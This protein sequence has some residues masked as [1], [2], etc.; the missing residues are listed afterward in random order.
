MDQERVSG[1]QTTHAENTSIE[2]PENRGVAIPM[3]SHN[4]PTCKLISTGE[5]LELVRR[6]PSV[7]LLDVRTP[8]EYRGESGH[9][10]NSVLV[11]LQELEQRI[12]ELVP[13]KAR[14][15]IAYCRS[16]NRSG[17]A[18]ATLTRKGFSA[19]NMEGG[20]VKWNAENL[21]VIHEPNP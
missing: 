21:P 10:E 14:T 2:R 8:D 11:P 17:T 1:R 12:D 15:I 9:L 5:T 4:A 16:G 19:M 7:L 3:P 20:M 13:Y 6:D 18:A